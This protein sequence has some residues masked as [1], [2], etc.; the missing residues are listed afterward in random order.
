MLD[1]R[2]VFWILGGVL[3]I[4]FLALRPYARPAGPDPDLRL[5]PRQR[6]LVWCL[7]WGG[8]LTAMAAGESSWWSMGEPWRSHLWLLG[9]S[10]AGAGWLLRWILLEVRDEEADS[11]GALID[12]SRSAIAATIPGRECDGG[13]RI[14][15][16][17]TI[18]GS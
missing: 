12:E 3:L 15:V 17:A 18:L 4:A 9:L 14:M 16:P 10:C 7:M 13:R 1:A 6:R 2:D 8:L 5:G 11:E